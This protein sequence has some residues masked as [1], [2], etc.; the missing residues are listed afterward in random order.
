MSH[1]SVVKQED[2]SYRLVLSIEAKR[3]GYNNLAGVTFEK[4]R[5]AQDLANAIKDHVD[6]KETKAAEKAA[7]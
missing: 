3:C 2:G 4:Y 5:A 7:E 6:N 1:A